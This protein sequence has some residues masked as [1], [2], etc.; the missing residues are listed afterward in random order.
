MKKKSVEERFMFTAKTVPES[1]VCHKC[2]M[3]GLGFE[4][5]CSQ[6]V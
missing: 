5:L 3:E 2:N 1:F 4:T 6:S